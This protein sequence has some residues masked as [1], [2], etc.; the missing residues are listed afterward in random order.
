VIDEELPEAIPDEPMELDD[1]DMQPLAGDPDR[2]TRIVK[3]LDALAK[4]QAFR[5]AL[6]KQP[7]E[8]A[9]FLNNSIEKTR[10]S[11]SNK[12]VTF[13]LECRDGLKLSA[14]P[15]CLT[16]IM[17]HLLDNA[18]KAVKQAGTV[19]CV[20]PWKRSMLFWQSRTREPGSVG[21]P[22]RI[23]MNGFIADQEAALA[24]GSPL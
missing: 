4:A 15:D 10:A 2:V 1:E 12:D 13:N 14:D 17:A 11:V 18:V 20:R 6:R 16:G 19:T 5:S 9:Q 23:S 21:R 3:G 7:I 8:L 24:W 22:F